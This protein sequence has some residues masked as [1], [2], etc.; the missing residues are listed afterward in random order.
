M[1]DS[2]YKSWQVETCKSRSESRRERPRRIF[3]IYRAR[4]LAPVGNGVAIPRRLTTQQ[5]RWAGLR[6]RVQRNQSTGFGNSE[7][8]VSVFCDTEWFKIKRQA[9][10]GAIS[11]GG[12]RIGTG[13][14]GRDTVGTQAVVDHATLNPNGH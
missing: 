7:A 14:G 10:S 12:R 8:G 3:E 1:R 2:D 11:Q 4:A 13:R 6:A 9:F 5:H